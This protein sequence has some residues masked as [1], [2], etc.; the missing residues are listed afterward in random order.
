[1]PRV[2]FRTG[3][4]SNQWVILLQ[5][6][7]PL[8]L[9]CN[10]IIPFLQQTPHHGAAPDHRVC[11]RNVHAAH[12]DDVFDGHPNGYPNGLRCGH[13]PSQRKV[14]FCHRQPLLG[15]A[16]VD[17]GLCIDHHA[18][19]S[20]THLL[21]GRFFSFFRIYFSALC[22][23]FTNFLRHFCK[24]SNQFFS[25]EPASEILH[26]RIRLIKTWRAGQSLQKD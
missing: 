21:F 12:A 8:V 20:Y 13:V 2:L 23:F 14:L 5:N 26:A 25:L 18:P 24:N 6:N 19:V 9:F 16:E 22:L 7:K 11:F 10:R 15:P 17:A 1:M 3:F 4:F